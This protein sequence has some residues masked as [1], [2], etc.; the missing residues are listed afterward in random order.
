MLNLFSIFLSSASQGV[1]WALLAIGVYITFRI[2]DI[3]DLTAEGSFPLGAGIAAMSITTGIHPLLACLLG[4]LGGALAG[5]VSGLL[6]TKLKIPALLAGIITMTGLYSVTS[7][8]MGAPNISLLGQP[9]IF[10]WVESLG[11]SK[12]TAVLIV[13]LCIALL[14]VFL[15]VFFLRTETGLAIR[16]T[17]D[18]LAMS[19]ANGINTDNMKI[20]GY[21]ISNGCIALAGSLLAQNNGFADLNSGIGTIVIG[22]ASIIIA[23][24]LFR[25]QPLLSRFLTVIL[26]A[27][28]YRF[29]LALVFELNVEPSDSKLASALV[30]VICLSFPQIQEKLRI[31]KFNRGGNNK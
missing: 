24:V 29:I 6:H 9:T 27:V 28:I 4:F 25:N 13:G 26:G 17:G 30:L 7:R 15:L 1:L 16:A 14:I 8:V 10:E 11:V 20:I 21:M 22:L 31:P 2:L 19:E 18:N 3:A 12:T 23:E 5:L